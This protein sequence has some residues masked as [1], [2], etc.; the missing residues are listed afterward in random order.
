MVHVR[1]DRRAQQMDQA[2]HPAALVAGVPRRAGGRAEDG[3]ERVP[4]VGVV[5]QEVAVW[6]YDYV[7]RDR[8]VGYCLVPSITQS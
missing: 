3:T 5:R 2:R 1:P 4:V 7:R 8:G 6:V